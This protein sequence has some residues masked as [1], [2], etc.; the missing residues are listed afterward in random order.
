VI[1]VWAKDLVPKMA[2]ALARLGTKKSWIVHAE[3]GLDE[4]SLAGRTFIG[5]VD[6]SSVTMLELRP[7]D[8]GIEHSPIADSASASAPESAEMIRAVLDG[9]FRGSAAEKLVLINA[10][11]ALHLAGRG[12]DRTEA[13]AVAVDSLDSGR[14]NEKLAM[15]ANAVRK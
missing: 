10:A 12:E 3:D 15:L 14:A 13:Y 7:D 11:A 4:I 8:F 6:G 2:N 9:G 1:G 5:E